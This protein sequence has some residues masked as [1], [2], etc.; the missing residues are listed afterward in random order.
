MVIIDKTILDSKSGLFFVVRLTYR[1]LVYKAIVACSHVFCFNFLFMSFDSM[2]WKKRQTKWKKKTKKTPAF[3]N[4]LLSVAC[5]LKN[6][7]SILD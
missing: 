5:R 6:F 2:K 3:R 1:L 4:G 7:W